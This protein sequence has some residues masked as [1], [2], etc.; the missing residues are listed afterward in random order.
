MA[1]KGVFVVRINFLEQKYC[2][3]ILGV[4]DLSD[5]ALYWVCGLCS[6]LSFVDFGVCW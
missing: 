4:Y 5:S 1:D 3:R 6:M 2:T